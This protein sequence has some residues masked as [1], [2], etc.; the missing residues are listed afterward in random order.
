MRAPGPEGG[1]SGDE[2]PE[3]ARQ[4]D[5]GHVVTQLGLGA[6]P[7]ERTDA[8][9]QQRALKKELVVGGEPDQRGRVKADADGQDTDEGAD[10]VEL[11]VAEYG[12]SEESGGER[13]QQVTVSPV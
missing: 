5:R 1:P 7:G 8:D 4:A 6:P 13:R 3:P 9:D 11:A 10:D 12:R 2:R